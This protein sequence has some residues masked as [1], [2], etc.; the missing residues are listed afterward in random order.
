MNETVLTVVFVLAVTAIFSFFSFRQKQSSWTGIVVDKKYTEADTD[1]DSS[2]PEK[3]TV[4]FK[5]N[6]GKKVKVTVSKADY[7]NY[8]IGDTATKTKG[9]YYP[10]KI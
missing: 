1:D 6:M 8:Q 10:V 4:T 9:S 7:D 3:H 5:T 2:T